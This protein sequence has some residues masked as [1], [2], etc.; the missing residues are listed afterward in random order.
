MSEPINGKSTSYRKMKI[1]NVE[2]NNANQ[3]VDKFLAKEF[4]SPRKT[5]SRDKYTRGEIIRQIK[6]GNILINSKKIKPSY[7]LKESD[8]IEIN[9]EKKSE[10]LIP[11][12]NIKFEII[13]KNENIIVV[14]KPAGIS[15]HPVKLD[16]DNTLANGLI[17]Q[18]PEIENVGDPSIG[19]GQVNIRP[20][21][22]HRLD[23]DTS[24]IMVVARNQKTL[25]EL[26]KKFKNR[27]VE[28]KYLAIVHGKLENKTGVIEKPLARSV[29]Y[30]KQIIAGRKTKTKIRT[31][32]TEY[33]IVKEFP[34]HSLVEVSPK[35]GRMHQIRVHMKSIGHP[36]AGDKIYSS[37][38]AKGNNFAKRQMLH[39]KS[40]KFTLFKKDY[41]FSAGF[42]EDFR[43][44]LNFLTKSI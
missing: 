12:K 36:V 34:D 4:F 16:E 33:K 27:E 23:K 11:N 1:I 6:N 43:I 25:E 14:N 29:N 44:A 2:K 32:V 7:I 41:D 40:I 24:G 30:R 28:K 31:A 38:G 19:S 21:I 26:K 3:R 8:K 20:G 39:A 5:T 17:F 15:V 22:V 37:K 35:T 10:K 13:Y 9:F 42:P 18:F